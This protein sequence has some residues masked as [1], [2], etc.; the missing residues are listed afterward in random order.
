MLQFG[1]LNWKVKSGLGEES[2]QR[3]IRELEKP[4]TELLEV[5]RVT[6]SE[7]GVDR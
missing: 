4:P 3:A 2:A 7:A 6:S 5:P 1:A